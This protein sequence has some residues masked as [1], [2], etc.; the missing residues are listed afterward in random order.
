[1]LLIF[2]LCFLLVLFSDRAQVLIWSDSRSENAG[3]VE[4]CGVIARQRLHHPC[5]SKPACFFNDRLY[6]LR[7]SRTVAHCGFLLRWLACR[8]SATICK[9]MNLS[10]S[11]HCSTARKS[12]FSVVGR[13]S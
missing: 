5:E 6:A 9:K 13:R 1:A 8:Y 7:Q 10:P 3:K 4:W 2:V 11:S 12:R